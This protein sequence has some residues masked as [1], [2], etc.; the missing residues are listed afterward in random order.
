MLFSTILCKET[1][2]QS[3]TCKHDTNLHALTKEK[4]HQHNHTEEMTESVC[5]WEH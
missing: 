3:K 4:H 1:Q 2:Q 5:N